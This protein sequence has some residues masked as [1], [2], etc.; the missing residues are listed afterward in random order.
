MKNIILLLVSGLAI[1]SSCSLF[2]DS[3]S[4]ICT[5]S[6]NYVNIKVVNNDQ[7]PIVLD[8]FAVIDGKTGK[9]YDLCKVNNCGSGTIAGNPEKGIYTLMHDHYAGEINGERVLIVN[10]KNEDISFQEKFSV[11]DDGC[12]ISMRSGPD[13]IIIQ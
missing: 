10:G 2:S 7:E 12:H 13:P 11:Y 5:S 1:F 8:E 6:F 4:G 9:N 3:E